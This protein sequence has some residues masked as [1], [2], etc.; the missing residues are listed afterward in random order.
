MKRTAVTAILLAAAMGLSA[1]GTAGTASMNAADNMSSSE[2]ADSMTAGT[3]GTV[4]KITAAQAYARMQSGD[5]VTIVD[6]R[7]ADEY[8]AKHIP[9]AILVPNEEIGDT[10]P[11]EL[12]D[13]NAEI[14]VYC[15]SGHRSALAA[16]KLADMGYT[17]IYD[18]GGIN[19]WTYETE[20][21]A[22]DPKSAVKSA[23]KDAAKNA[24]SAA[25][26]AASAA[27]AA[28]STAYTVP[29]FTTTGLDGKTYD[30]SIFA[31]HKLTMVNVWATYCGPCINEL[32]ELA[33]LS[34]ELKDHDIQIIGVV[35]DV[36]QSDDGSFDPDGVEAARELV[37]RT[38]ADDYIHI[39]PSSQLISAMLTGIYA[40][41]TTIFFNEKGQQVGVAYM[42][43]NSAAKW[44]AI[45]NTILKGAQ[46]NG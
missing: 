44:T 5:P 14:L 23:V 39:L 13:K 4:T 31:G 15:R 3:K 41:P 8:A 45:I 27:V 11:A 12:P 10:A 43:A 26:S 19:D 9:G 18:F 2:N 33:Q 32:P 37:S 29:A 42:G 22:W 17:K 16:K 36:M 7:T 1:C 21:G 24:A 38:G 40:V 34:S 25:V 46:D 30:Q 6:V 35:S 20:T 28:D